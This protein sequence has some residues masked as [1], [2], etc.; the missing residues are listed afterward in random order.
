M[1]RP[2][3]DSTRSHA[4]HGSAPWCLGS[5]SAAGRA[6]GRHCRTTQPSATILN[7]GS[8]VMCLVSP[9][10]LVLK[11]SSADG[12][13][14]MSSCHPGY[15][16]YSWRSRLRPS[17]LAAMG[18][19]RGGEAGGYQ[20]VQSSAAWIAAR[21]A[22]TSPCDPQ[23]SICHHCGKGRKGHTFAQGDL[24]ASEPQV[25]WS[26]VADPERAAG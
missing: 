16:S 19:A 10:V 5:G 15:R 13:R 25:E 12:A 4:A 22:C 8:G 20:L 14:C 17:L 2:T 26:A 3:R 23:A 1:L 9:S 18:G 11:A 6:G 21:S 24:R 7:C